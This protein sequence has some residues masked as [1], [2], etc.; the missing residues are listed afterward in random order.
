V[1]Y[2]LL[3][4]KGELGW[5]G[6]TRQQVNDRGQ[7]QFLKLENCYVSGDGQ[8]LRTFPGFGTFIDLNDI[9]NST[10]FSRYAP[11]AV[12]PVLEL[13]ELFSPNQ[14]LLTTEYS[15]SEFPR[16]RKAYDA[17]T[18]QTV[19]SRAKP[20]SL[21]GFEQIGNEIF[22][23]GE[24]RFR[25]N[26]IYDA[27]S[28]QLTVTNYIN[29]S[30]ASTGAACGVRLSGTPGNYDFDAA[31]GG[32]GLQISDVVYFEG[33]TSTDPDTQAV[34]DAD[35]NGKMHEVSAI[36]GQ[37]ITLTTTQSVAI[38]SG[39]PQ[40]AA[41]GEI[42]RIRPNRSYN[43]PT[44]A[45]GPYVAD[46]DDRPD[47]PDALTVWRVI[48]GVDMLDLVTQNNYPCYPAWVANRVR[49]FG[50]GLRTP[51]IY[52]REGHLT[53]GSLLSPTSFRSRREQRRLPYRPCL[54]PAFDR[55]IVAAPQYS[56]MLQIPAVVQTDPETWQTGT[57]TTRG[58]SWRN[59]DIYDKPRALGL[60]K[61]RLVEGPDSLL[62]PR[63]WGPSPYAVEA[64]GL[65][66]AQLQYGWTIDANFQ[67]SP[68]TYQAA[69][70][71]FDPGTGEEGLASNPITAVIPDKQVNEYAWTVRIPYVH[72][73]YVMPESMP[74]FIN[75]YLS[76]KNGSALGYYGTF[77]LMGGSYYN[78]E[79]EDASGLFGL[80][81]DFEQKVVG[82]FLLPLPADSQDPA[83][84][85][86]FERAPPLFAGMP[87]GSEACRYI[88]GV[89]F[90]GGCMGNAGA[91]KQLW[92][93]E[94]SI[95]WR[96][97]GYLSPNDRLLIA[98]HNTSS[99]GLALSA[100]Q[101]DGGYQGGPMGGA[102]RCFP[103]AYQGVEITESDL[104]PRSSNNIRVDQVLNR[105]AQND[106]SFGL[107]ANQQALVHYEQ[108]KLTRP[109]MDRF[110]NSGTSPTQLNFKS[111]QQPV[112]YVM[113]RGQLQISDPGEPGRASKAFIKI[114]D[115]KRGG[116]I[117]AIGQ[118][119]GNAIVCTQN[120]T[121]SY[122]WFRNV[123][124]DEPNLVSEQFG[125]IGSNT[126][127]EFDGG[128]AW[129]SSRGPV[130]LGQ[131]IQH[132]GLPIAESF[133]RPVGN[134]SA[135][136]LRDSQGMMRH[137][138]GVHD[139]QRGL[140]M[141]G[142]VTATATSSITWEGQTYTGPNSSSVTDEM[143]SRWPCDEVLI[144][145]YKAN[146]FSTW[147]P[148]AGLE[149][150][151]MR[152][153]RDSKGVVRMCFL[154]ADNVIYSLDDE[155]GD[156]N[157]VFGTTMEG[158]TSG[159]A[160][161]PSTTLSF[162]GLSTYADGD[163]G[164]ALK[165]NLAAYLRPGMLVELLDA[166]GNVTASTTI[167]SVTSTSEDAL[168]AS[169]VTLTAALTWTDNQAV[170]IGGR[171]RT[172]VTSTFIGAETMDVMQAQSVQMRYGT[173]GPGHA[174]ARVRVF[175][176][177]DGVGAGE[178]SLPCWFTNPD[179]W[180]ALGRT[181]PGTS[182]PAEIAKLGRRRTFSRGQVAGQ[183]LSVHIE[184]TGQSQ[185]RIQDIAL[186]VS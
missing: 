75:V 28:T 53:G 76:E 165:K 65:W 149:I 139:E 37:N 87:R 2:R 171:P 167:A 29:L 117:K 136:Y 157:G 112:H 158:L 7:R 96:S 68:G 182:V 81:P 49:D 119:N 172:T 56:C 131:G 36:V 12:R 61:P 115:P 64:G 40:P 1:G 98:A 77:D 14:T 129:L 70:A 109:I 32:N 128:L 59:N 30:G 141:W 180:E 58:L 88:R 179:Q 102:G 18:S 63:A 154:A 186:E 57:P 111:L 146:A 90:S 100:Y 126:M 130:A 170:R 6:L 94:A 89:L 133:Y 84:S 4:I 86:D 19:Y 62:S 116:D 15:H 106:Q 73:G 155:W 24:S 159:A 51:D 173:D 54:E 60:P 72:P 132:V 138:W 8:E 181:K 124:A 105:F 99:P 97:N 156:S 183:E 178:E 114:V 83:A 137:S 82:E 153:L 22:V 35:I 166:N 3:S 47:D 74:S 16:S 50:D 79:P 125:C 71:F 118:L 46:L 38:S 93:G 185:V 127:V 144:W 31:A 27:S 25:E 5:G 113:P 151:W 162:D 107:R 10:G 55:I 13:P 20:T 110:R 92:A 17:A 52:T 39:A 85:I 184:L 143:L 48:Q 80:D 152:P 121:Y 135:E 176:I 148:P 161:Q 45:Q 43:Y 33:L 78:L 134:T 142:L 44:T 163:T 66:I 21:F 95:D 69:A 108:I 140:V 145:S 42:H 26:P 103:D 101:L 175:K 120:E 11:D 67:M 123:G 164:Y 174:N 150:L 122:S 23:I 177:E 147:R 104:L 160:T 169:V 168:A 41:V 91:D 9:N 34:L